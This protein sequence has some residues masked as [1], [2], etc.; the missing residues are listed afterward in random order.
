MNIL[1]LLNNNFMQ[2]SILKLPI[3]LI[4]LI[5]EKIFCLSNLISNCNGKLIF[6]EHEQ[7]AF[8]VVKLYPVKSQ[9]S[10]H[11]DILLFL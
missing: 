10:S 6:V 4:S 8:F 11:I 2:E 9:S 5:F 7:I 3:F 1:F